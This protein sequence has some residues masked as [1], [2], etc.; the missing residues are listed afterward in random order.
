MQTYDNGLA[1][2][3]RSS[4]SYKHSSAAEKPARDVSSGVAADRGSHK[5]ETD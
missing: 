3:Y 5:R 4:S 1:G 2:K